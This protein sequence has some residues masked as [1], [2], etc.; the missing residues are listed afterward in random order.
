MIICNRLIDEGFCD[1][2]P[3]AKIKFSHILFTDESPVE[4]FAKPNKQNRRVRTANLE[5]IEPTQIAKFTL[6]IMVCGG[7]GRYG[8]TQ[9]Y[10]V[11]KHATVN[12]DC[13]RQHILAMYAECVQQKFS[14]PERTILM[15]DGATDDS[16]SFNSAL[17]SL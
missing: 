3:S 15:Q 10:V 2:S 13:Y 5:D 16:K 4:L 7:I 17:L 12:G 1:D 11:D 14:C 9:L 6:K 8:K